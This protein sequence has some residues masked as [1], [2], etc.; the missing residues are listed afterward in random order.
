MTIPARYAKYTFGNA[1]KPI[2]VPIGVNGMAVK[3]NIPINALPVRMLCF[4]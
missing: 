4:E 2:A 3:M 1:V